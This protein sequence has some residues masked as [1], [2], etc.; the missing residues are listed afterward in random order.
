MDEEMAQAIKDRKVVP[1]KY[2][3][4]AKMLELNG[5]S[6]Y[7]S[8]CCRRVLDIAGDTE[9]KHI[10]L[11]IFNCDVLIDD[12]GLIACYDILQGYISSQKLTEYKTYSNSCRKYNPQ[13]INHRMNCHLLQSESESVPLKIS[14]IAI[15]VILIII[16]TFN[17]SLKYRGMVRH[18]PKHIN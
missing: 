7:E 6:E 1:P 17:L 11:D 3:S 4:V 14:I 9:N 10:I 16:H 2:I 5:M 8:V 13:S 12:I 18:S 15:L